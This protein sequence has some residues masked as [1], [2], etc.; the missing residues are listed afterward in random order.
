MSSDGKEIFDFTKPGW[1]ATPSNID[2]VMSD[3]S[4]GNLP[5]NVPFV[6]DLLSNFVFR[7]V[8]FDGSLLLPKKTQTGYHLPGDITLCDNRSVERLVQNI[9]PVLDLIGDSP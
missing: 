8:D 4:N 3:I 9:M 1:M 6:L 5:E 7:F 2:K